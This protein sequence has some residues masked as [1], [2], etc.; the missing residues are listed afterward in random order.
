MD[1][2]TSADPDRRDA[3]AGEDPSQPAAG[4]PDATDGSAAGAATVDALRRGL[5]DLEDTVD[6]PSERRAVERARRLVDEFGDDEPDETDETIR[7]F[8]R[9]D[10]A[11]AFVGAIL[12]S[13]PLL[14][15]DGVFAIAATL[16]AA[17]WLWTLNVAFLLAMTVGLLYVADFREI[18]ITRPIFGLVPRR[19]LG[20]LLVSFLTAAFTMTLWGR[21]D[22]WSD[23]AVALSRIS[24][25]WTVATFG[26]AIGDILPGESSARDIN[27]EL[28]DIGERIGVGDDEGL[29]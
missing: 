26:A 25:V 19:L 6:D 14:V 23:P 4:E 27:D 10:I 9:R 16:R 7:K 1:A 18:T 12:V 21:L 11:E 29:F 8:T 5:E 15:E 17:P 2:G 3:A 20:V 24:V 13:L 28:D 22:G